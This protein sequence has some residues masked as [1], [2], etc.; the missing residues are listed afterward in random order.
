[1]KLVKHGGLYVN[2]VRVESADDTL[3]QKEHLLP[4]NTTLLRFGMRVKNDFT[5]VQS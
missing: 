5:F 4:G 1:M 3:G 2:S